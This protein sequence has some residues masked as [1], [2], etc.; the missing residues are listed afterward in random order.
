MACQQDDRWQNE[1]YEKC[2]NAFDSYL[3]ETN[4]PSAPWYIID[5]EQKNGRSYRHLRF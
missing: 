1:H 2:L 5:A 3:K 4:L